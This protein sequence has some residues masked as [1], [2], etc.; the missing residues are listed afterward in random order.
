MLHIA[1]SANLRAIIYRD[2][3]ERENQNSYHY[4]I[5]EDTI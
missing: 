2:A 4:Q 3:S 1:F 5:I